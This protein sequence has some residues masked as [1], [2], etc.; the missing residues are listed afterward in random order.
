MKGPHGYRCQPCATLSETQ[1]R[2]EEIRS[3]NT[4]DIEQVGVAQTCFLRSAAFQLSVRNTVDRAA[5]RDGS[6][7]ILP[8]ALPD[9]LDVDDLVEYIENREEHHRKTTLEQYRKL[10]VEAGVEFDA[11]YML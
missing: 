1:N 5:R 8:A 6:P 9:R 11:R 3:R 10:P 2:E 4:V 7:R